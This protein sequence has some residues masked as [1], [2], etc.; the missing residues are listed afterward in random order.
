MVGEVTADL[1]L[2]FLMSF[3]VNYGI[4]GMDLTDPVHGSQ[5]AIAIMEFFHGASYSRMELIVTFGILMLVITLIGGLFGVLCAYTAA[6]AAQGMGYDLR[7]DAYGKVMS[8]SIEQTDQFTTGSLITRMTN[9]IT[10]V[11]D[12]FEMLM[13]GFVRSPMFLIGGTAMLL[14]LDLKFTAVLL[15]SIP[16]MAVVLVTVLSRAIPLYSLIQKKLDNVNN[17]MQENVTGARVVKAY[18][19]E[20]YECNRFDAANR[21][22][23][24]VNYTV[25]KLMAVI[26]PVLTVLLNLAIVAIIYIGG[27]NIRIENAGMTTGSIMAAITYM[28]QVLNALMMVTNVFQQISRAS[29]SAKRV[30]E[31]LETEPVVVG[32]TETEG[33]TNSDIAVSFQNVSFRYPD[34]KDRPVL[35]HINLDVKKGETLAIIGATGSGKSSLVALIPRFY[36]AVEGTVSVMGRPVQEYSLTS[37]RQKIGYVMQKSELFSDT[38]EGNIRWGKPDATMEE[39]E[40]AAEAAQATE[41]INGFGAKFQSY[42]A[43]KGASLSGGQKQRMSIARAFLRKP[44]I[45]ILDD[46]TSALDLATESRLRQAIHKRMQGTTVIMI[47]QR[48]ASVIEADRI[49][50]IEDDGTIRH[51][52]THEQLLKTSDTY[53]SIYDSQMKSGAYIEKNTGVTQENSFANQ[54]SLEPDEVT[55][56]EQKGGAQSDG[57]E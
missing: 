20:A 47:A 14:M 25:A 33:R 51:C 30:N 3:I 24:D 40:E 55:V 19:Q 52:D 2:P 5:T 50:V 15:C 6:R 54:S 13:R 4:T 53:R 57:R 49:A 46:A 7:K 18:V 31:I 32:G 27:W 34:T 9:D 16:V 11:V 21:E 44:E 35:Q 37:L 8:F 22:L 29:A 42:I 48:I 17:V 36:D 38:V 23:T 1:L 45:L 10:M 12:F 26:S 39:V 56:Q 28:T 43:E 41:F